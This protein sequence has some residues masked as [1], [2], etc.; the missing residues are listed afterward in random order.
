VVKVERVGIFVAIVLCLSGMSRIV[1]SDDW[2]QVVHGAFVILVGILVWSGL[3]AH[4][5]SVQT[6]KRHKSD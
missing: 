1:W 4:A 6:S 3:K 2:W 5:S